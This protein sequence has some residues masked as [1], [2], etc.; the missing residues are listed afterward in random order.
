MK[1]F[2]AAVAFLVM[3]TLAFGQITTSSVVGAASTAAS[4]DLGPGLEGLKANL[5]EDYVV[6]AGDT[7]KSISASVYGDYRYWTFIYLTNKGAVAN[8]ERI[9][10][11]LALKIY[12][13]GF[14]PKLPN[15]LSKKVIAETY[16]QSYAR[17]VELGADWTDARRWVLLEATAFAPD[18]FAAAAARIDDSD[19]AWYKAR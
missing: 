18:L 19:E 6:R 7:L 5:Q 3:A 2:F 12:K 16:L 15:D 9:E 13:L 14:D 17:Y 10:P 8:P 4:S 11:G 1:K